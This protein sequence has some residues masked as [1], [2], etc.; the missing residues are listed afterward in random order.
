[1]NPPAAANG[2]FMQSMVSKY[3]PHHQQNSMK[4]KSDLGNIDG[5]SSASPGFPNQIINQNSL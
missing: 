5:I 4:H 3:G 2:N 1:M